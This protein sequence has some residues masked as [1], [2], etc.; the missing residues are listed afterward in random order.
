MCDIY[1]KD[2]ILLTLSSSLIDLQS[3]FISSTVDAFLLLDFGYVSFIHLIDSSDGFY[4]VYDSDVWDSILVSTLEKSNFLFFRL[5]E[6]IAFWVD[7]IDSF[8]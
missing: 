6:E 4:F 5:L 3:H 2:F 8:I 1:S 7:Y